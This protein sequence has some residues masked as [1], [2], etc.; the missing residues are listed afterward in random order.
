MEYSHSVVTYMF[1]RPEQTGT[2]HNTNSMQVLKPVRSTVK[3][4]I[5]TLVR[6]LNVSSET[7]EVK[8]K[9]RYNFTSRIR[10][11]AGSALPICAQ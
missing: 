8:N 9:W 11:P 1:I 6:R 10:L 5:M 2:V 3:R 7:A 4:E